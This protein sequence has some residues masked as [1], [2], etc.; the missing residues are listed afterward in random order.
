M[1][2]GK[3]STGWFL[4]RCY[5]LGSLR[6]MILQLRHGPTAGLREI[7]RCGL[8]TA[9]A[10]RL[11]LLTLRGR[12]CSQALVALCQ[13]VQSD[14]DRLLSNADAAVFLVQ[15]M[16]A[17][18]QYEKVVEIMNPF[19]KPRPDRAKCY[20]ARGMAYLHLGQ[21]PEAL[22]DLTRCHELKPSVCRDHGYDPQRAFLHGL[23]G[24]VKGAR[25]V[26][27]DLLRLPT[28]R[29]AGVE[30]A[31]F[32]H[33]RLRDKLARLDLRGSV[34]V[35]LS[36]NPAALGHAILDP[37]HYLNLFRQ[38]FDNLVMVHPD[39]SGYT[40]ATRVAMSIL[41][42]Y[43]DM[44]ECDEPAV[45]NFTWQ[46]LGELQHDNCTFLVYNYW[47]LNRLAFKS[48]LDP[49]HALH[50]GRHYLRPPHKLE[51]RAEALLRRNGCDLSGLLVVVHSREQS[52]H[53]LRG[54]SYRDTDAHHYIP[55]LRKLIALGYK[56]VRIGD[57]KMASLRRDV[58]GLVELPMTDFY[59]PMLDPYLISR[60]EFMISCQSGPC[61]YARV[62]GKPNLVVNA[63]YHYTFLPEHKE[64]LA[65]KNYR[66]AATRRSA[67]CRG[68][69]PGRGA[70]LRSHP[71]LRG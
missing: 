59:S 2:L 30:L 32:L 58:S 67:Q 25:R 5:V 48:R 36:A 3:L 8:R 13:E 10:A 64:L 54:Q 69:S 60:C 57:R 51:A 33:Q 53:E 9:R 35:F 4:L 38:R 17:R 37:F 66:N 40:P 49:E 68:D 20:G 27:V 56:V 70:P 7:A 26:M 46:H 45:L 15:P 23:R 16:L 11:F 31:A 19:A 14:P 22:A 41:E 61:S 50:R 12:P 43:V 52:Y 47:A 55:A 71:A 6:R 18:Q 34:G 63:V 21:Y 65:F 1:R 29:P 62:F 24:D 42:Q 39:L 44:V 28:A